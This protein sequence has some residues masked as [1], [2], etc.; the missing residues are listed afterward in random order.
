[1]KFGL[2]YSAFLVLLFV[3][4]SAGYAQA[5][6]IGISPADVGFDNVLKGGYAEKTIAVSTSS[7]TSV[8]FHVSA[9]GHV[10][11]WIE[12]EPSE[13][14]TVSRDSMKRVTVIVRPPENVANGVYGGSIV[15]GTEPTQP[16]E[17]DVGVGVTTGA[18]AGVSITI[19]GEEIKKAKVE[20]ISVKDTEEGNPVEFVI[21]ITN[22]GNVIVTPLI[23]IEVTE[24]GKIEVVKSTAH[25]ETE[26]LPTTMNTIRI[27]MDTVDMDI[28]EYTG[29]VKIFLDGESLA[30]QA[31]SFS[32]FERGTLSKM[33]VLQKV[34]NEPWVKEGDIVKIDAYFENTGELVVAGKFKGEVYFGGGLVEVVE[35]EELEVPVGRTVVMSSY[36]KP[37]KQGLYVVRGHVVYGGKTTETKESFINVGS[38]EGGLSPEETNYIALLIAVVVAI[39]IIVVLLK[40]RLKRGFR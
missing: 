4:L 20:S 21:S 30:E 7:E 19:T 33:G 39:L 6:S 1:M 29:T 5:V 15:V 31:L 36:F 37:E 28:G 14:L 17:G 12:F 32:V 10:K 38:G 13:D 11:D 34:W 9:T 23:G 35:S 26:I 3:V 24:E 27:S 2:K 40:R 25:S 8:S 22:Q 16:G 18:A